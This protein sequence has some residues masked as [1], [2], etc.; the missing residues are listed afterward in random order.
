MF[1][2]IYYK[3]LPSTNTFLKEN[4]DKY[5]HYTVIICHDQTSGRGRL[6]RKW[7]MEPG[8]NIAMSILLKPKQ[9]T[10]VAK[11]SHLASA[12]VFLALSKYSP[13]FQIKW[14]ND[15]LLNGKK[16]SGILLESVYK[17]K[18]L[19]I[20]IGIGINVNTTIFSP[21]IKNKATSLKNELKQDFNL[22][23]II[24]DVLENFDF[25]YS[26]NNNEYLDICRNN[27]SII[28]KNVYLDGKNIY[29]IDLLNNGNLLIHDGNQEKE[30]AY[31]EITF[32]KN[33]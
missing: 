30:V 26:Q 29:V 13:H 16:V 32:E 12:A 1:R 19:A 4:Y 17:E 27:S 25:F 9:I 7:E 3:N 22:D 8:K 23:L 11:L 15:I 28:G 33:Y 5:N 2:K 6:D 31:G 20:I 24:D 14:P 18:F 10:E 21:Q